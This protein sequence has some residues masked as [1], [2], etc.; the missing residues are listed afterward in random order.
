[1]SEPSPPPRRASAWIE[2]FACDGFGK[3][4]VLTERKSGSQ[5]TRR[6]REMDSNFRS[7][8][9]TAFFSKTVPEPGDDKP[10]Q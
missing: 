3:P 9:G 1:M 6:W 10:A 4:S 8:V 2:N 5:V 7:P